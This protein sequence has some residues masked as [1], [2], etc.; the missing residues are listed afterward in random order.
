ML[1]CL[2]R[3]EPHAPPGVLTEC[4]LMARTPTLTCRLPGAH[5]HRATCICAHMLAHTRV[6]VR[7]H[8]HSA[9]PQEPHSG[10]GPG[11]RAGP[12]HPSRLSCPPAGLRGL[13]QRARP[14]MLCQLAPGSQGSR[15]RQPGDPPFTPA[16]HRPH[17]R[18]LETWPPLQTPPA[19]SAPLAKCFHSEVKGMTFAPDSW[20][21]VIAPRWAGLMTSLSGRSQSKTRG[22]SRP[23]LVPAPTRPRSQN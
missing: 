18:W 3:G 6:H 11:G 9:G 20:T 17:P 14:P 21:R 15:C 10:P 13:G 23:G 5:A 22:A 4:T 12:G 1:C 19:I 16:A 8:T 7:V 2:G